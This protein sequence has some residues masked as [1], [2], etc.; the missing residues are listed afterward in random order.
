MHR[1]LWGPLCFQ[2][3]T[4]ISVCCKLIFQSK[5]ALRTRWTS[6]Q[7]NLREGQIVLVKS[8][9]DKPFQWPLGKIEKTFPDADGDVRVLSVRFRDRVKKRAVSAIVP[10]LTEETLSS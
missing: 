10:L 2:P 1:P 8:E 9:G 6:R 5:L 7:P 4:Y 3:P